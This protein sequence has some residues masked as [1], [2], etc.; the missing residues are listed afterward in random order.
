MICIVYNY[1]NFVD[2]YRYE[3]DTVLAAYKVSN[4][5]AVNLFSIF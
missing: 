1:A 3:Y 2:A 5:I 4:P